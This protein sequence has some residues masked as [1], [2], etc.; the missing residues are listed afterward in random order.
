MY[1]T[2]IVQQP[3]VHDKHNIEGTENTTADI[4]AVHRT[5]IILHIYTVVCW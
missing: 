2:V 3:P 5:H 1:C 4:V